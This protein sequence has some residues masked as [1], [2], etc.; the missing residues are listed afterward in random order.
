MIV[1]KAG[2]G[3]IAQF[4]I[5]DYASESMN[6]ARGI[7]YRSG[8]NNNYHSWATIL[9]DKN[10]NLYAVKKVTS[11]DNAIA[12]FDGTTGNIQNSQVTIDDN[13]TIHVKAAQYEDSYSGALDMNNSNIYKLNS[14]Y[15][16]D[17]ADNAAEGIH[18]Y[19]DA[20]HVD[21]LWVNSGDLL[22][23]PNRAL[24]TS[25]TRANS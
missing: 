12:R 23:V 3:G 8:W 14:I 1:T 6:T 10:Y 9:D 16:A 13:G 25:T 7:R 4:Y 21:T 19:R 15:T 18:F 17:A 5:N 11:T 24:G 2:T 22:F 20:T